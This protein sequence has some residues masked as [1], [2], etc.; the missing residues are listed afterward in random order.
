M[1]LNSW[2]EEALKR[3]GHLRDADPKNEIY[4]LV[5]AHICLIGGKA[6][7]ANG[8]WSPII[9]TGSPLEEMWR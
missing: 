9:I 7:E 4:L 6:D 2:V 1:D 3:I 5:H 8:F